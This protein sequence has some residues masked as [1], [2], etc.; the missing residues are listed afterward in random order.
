MLALFAV[1]SGVPADVVGLHNRLESAVN[2]GTCQTWCQDRFAKY[3]LK[4]RE[5]CDNTLCSGCSYCVDLL[6]ALQKE[7]GG[8]VPTQIDGKGTLNQKRAQARSVSA[9]IAEVLYTNDGVYGGEGGGAGGQ[10]RSLALCA[11]AKCGTTSIYS[12]LY[13]SIY[14]RSWQEDKQMNTKAAQHKTKMEQLHG[15]DVHKVS[16][17]PK[18]PVGSVSQNAFYDPNTTTVIAVVRDPLERYRSAWENK[19]RCATRGDN[20]K[21]FAAGLLRAAD[22]DF[23]YGEYWGRHSTKGAHSPD[24]IVWCMSFEHFALAMR[25]IHER[26]RQTALNEHFYPQGPFQPSSY[27]PKPASDEPLCA[28]GVVRKMTV[29]ELEVQAAAILFDYDGLHQLSGTP[30]PHEQSSSDIKADSAF[31][32]EEVSDATMAHALCAIVQ[33]EYAWLEQMEIYEDKCGGIQFETGTKCLPKREVKPEGE[34]GEQPQQSPTEPP[35]QSQQPVQP[36]QQQ[37]QTEEQVQDRLAREALEKAGNKVEAP[38]A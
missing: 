17:W 1:V 4:A 36:P 18:P 16:S 14:G 5:H 12:W 38:P 15:A 8:G 19:L 37:E 22:M 24:D 32:L 33:P 7:V 25:R 6:H 3:P 35:Q 30:F 31:E 13:E 26:G 27:G 23:T 29:E 28:A 2:A 10:P 20:S 21:E 34:T 11:C 9:G